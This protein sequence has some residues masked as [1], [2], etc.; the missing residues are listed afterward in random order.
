MREK[1]AQRKQE[2][3]KKEQSLLKQEQQLEIDR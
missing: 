2:V 3:D 1:I